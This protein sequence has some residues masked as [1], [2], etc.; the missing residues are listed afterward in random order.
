MWPQ[1]QRMLEALEKVEFFVVTDL[2]WNEAC[3]RADYVLP[4]CTAIERDQVVLTPDNHLFYLPSPLTPGDKLPDVEIMLRLAHAMDLHSEILDLTD[5][6]AYLDYILATAGVLLA[7]LKAAPEGL[8]ARVTKA[9]KPYSYERGLKTPSGKVEFVSGL[10]S[11]YDREGYAALPEFRD[12][13]ALAGDRA[14]YPFLLVSG[15]RRPQ[16]FH[17]C[18]YRVPWLSG[19]EAHPM[20]FLHPDDAARLGLAAGDAADVSTPLGT[21]RFTVFADIGVKPGV[22][23]IYHDDPGGNINRLIGS[24]WLDPISGFPGFR[25]T[26]CAVEKANA[27]QEVDSK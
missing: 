19:L 12:W 8:P 26:I 27:P 16:L 7:E 9:G 20:V 14:R 1:P 17:S 18:T 21:M 2:F 3:E 24:D 5:F 4:A 15:G 10:L 25:S 11:R 6:D 13:R 23:H 22:V